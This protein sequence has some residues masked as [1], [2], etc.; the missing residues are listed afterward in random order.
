MNT[1]TI[2]LSKEQ[3]LR[4]SRNILLPEIGRAGQAK[5]LSSRM[6]IVGAGALGSACA[7]YLAASGVGHIIIADYDT[8]DISNLQRQLSFSTS[9]CGRPKAQALCDRLLAINPEIEVSV[10]NKMLTKANVGEYI[11]GC[12]LVIEGSDNP[13][14]KYLV[15]EVCSQH[16]V[17][18]VL[19]GVAQFN[20][21]VMCWSPG[22][23]TY[24]EIFPEQAAEGGYTPC[25]LG[26]VL[27]PLP[28]IV[29]SW[30][31][32]EAIK[33]LTGAGTPLFGKLLLIDM[34]TPSAR[35]IEL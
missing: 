35:I 32:S 6:L 16:G 21:Q 28:G 7:M 1:G 34:L 29:A 9:D 31:A 12:D 4:Y 22:Y 13:A 33:I 30:Q 23:P 18:C 11:A 24:S 15:T 5:L 26:G 27:G 3:R 2:E 19:G 25:S 14:T 10:I 8:I 20:G 17:P